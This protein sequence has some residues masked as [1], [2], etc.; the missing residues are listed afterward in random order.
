[1]EF[2][3]FI[4]LFAQW[5]VQYSTFTESVRTNRTTRLKKSTNSSPSIFGSTEIVACCN[6]PWS[7]D[8][9]L[10]LFAGTFYTFASHINRLTAEWSL[11][12][13]C[14]H[15]PRIL[16]GLVHCQFFKH[17]I[18][19]RY[20]TDISLQRRTVN[21]KQRETAGHIGVFKIP[22]VSKFV[23]WLQNVDYVR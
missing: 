18:V 14:S 1:M 20:S 15:S 6:S 16:L 9:W 7:C 17:H 2:I 4:Y 23:N 11:L 10:V 8:L 12:M 22:A 3:Y 5:Q 13:P 19:R 21:I